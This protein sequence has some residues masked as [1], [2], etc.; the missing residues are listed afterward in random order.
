[1]K[2]A[3]VALALISAVALTGCA[4]QQS[5]SDYLLEKQVECKEAGGHMEIYK[6]SS[7][8]NGKI[9]ICILPG[10]VVNLDK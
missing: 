4:E 8:M 3:F 10:T 5:Y 2:K 7:M 6:D 9:S 1:M